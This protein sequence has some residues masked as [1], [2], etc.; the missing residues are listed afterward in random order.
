MYLN[1]PNMSMQLEPRGR[2][3]CLCLLGCPDS[4]CAYNRP[5]CQSDDD[6]FCHD[7]DAKRNSKFDHSIPIKA[8]YHSKLWRQE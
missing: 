1:K 4:L 5:D 3:H 8:V 2:Y 7:K 6:D